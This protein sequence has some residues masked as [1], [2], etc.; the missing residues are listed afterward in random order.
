NDGSGACAEGAAAIGCPGLGLPA[1]DEADLA[2][3]RRDADIWI[4][5]IWLQV[6]YRK[7]RFELELATIQGSIENTSNVPGDS[8]FINPGS[9][10]DGWRIARWGLATEIEQKLIEDR[11]RLQFNFG[12]SSGDPDVNAP[13]G[14]GGLIPGNNGLQP[15]LGDRTFSTFSFHPSYRVD[16]ILNRN[17][18]QRIQGVYYFRPGVEYDFVRKP[19]GQRFGGG[20]AGIWTR[21]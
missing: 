19:N 15:Q 14:G 10:D 3:V 6:L 12:W 17:I 7:F 13:A 4:P 1:G 20:F 9:G 16:L 11:L 2:Y 8:N 18:L 21:A 5:D